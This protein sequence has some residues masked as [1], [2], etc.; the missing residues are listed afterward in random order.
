MIPTSPWARLAAVC[1]LP[2]FWA[3]PPLALAT[4]ADA[5]LAL[6][7]CTLSHPL[8]LASLPARCGILAVREDPDDRRGASINLAIAVVPALDRRSQAVPLFLLAGGPGQAAQDLYTSYASV[9]TRINREHDIV[10]VDQRGTG[11]SGRL[12]CAFPEDWDVAGDALPALQA[13]VATCLAKLGPRVRFYTTSVAVADLDAV[14]G[15]LG[16]SQIALY[17]GSY[18]TRTAELYMRRHKA[19]VAAA[20]LDGVLDPVSIIGPDM[21]RDGER[22]LENILTR[23]RAALDC[24]HA[25]PRLAAELAELRQRFGNEVVYVDVADA[26]TGANKSLPFNRSLLITALR[27]LSY[28]SQQ[29][30]LLPLAI[31]AGATGNL[32]ILAE[33][34]IMASS[35]ISAAIAI[36]M[37][38]SVVCAEDQP[39]YADAKIDRAAMAR[40]YQGTE[41]I[42]GLMDICKFWPRG[43]VD[44]DLH[45]PLV[46][47]IPT[48]L[49][50]GTADPVTPPGGAERAARSL[51]RHRHIVINGEGH[52]QLAAGCMPKLMAE[53][54]DRP[55]P[56]ALDI[57]CLDKYRPTPFFLSSAG[58]AP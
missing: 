45:A 50:S 21:P 13:A 20:I 29:A 14:R 30:A 27:F 17:G 35:G 2:A 41:Q 5:K 46:T 28:N 4:A 55:D 34:A 1:A 23:C 3:L 16:Y 42:D 47:G 26:K 44:A 40:F 54:L 53:F 58:P 32:R 11:H 33:Q 15:A 36:G 31:H 9:F 25:F 10:L 24:N 43:P 12:D 49:L 18:G 48:L 39:F 51:S 7:D 38:N 22:G 52:G 56:L 6:H 8:R 37:H 57:S 19:N